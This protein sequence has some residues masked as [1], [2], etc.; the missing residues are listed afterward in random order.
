MEKYIV[1]L[2]INKVNNFIYVGV[3]KTEDPNKFDTYLGCG[4]YSN[5]PKSYNCRETA[6]QCAVAKYGPKNFR[7]KTLRIF[8]SLKPALQL[9]EKIVTQQFIER[10]D[11]YN[12]TVGGG[13]PPSSNKEIYQYDLEG[14]FIKEWKSI[15]SITD[16][17]KVNKDRVRMVINDKRSFEASYWSE[18]CFNH[19]DVTE[20]R[21]S[22]RGSIRQYTTDG[23]FL[24]SFRNTTEAAKQ[25]DIE[26]NQITNAICDKYATNGYW[27]LKEGETIES[28]LDGSIKNEPKVYLYSTS[29][30]FIK[31]FDNISAV[32]KEYKYN[33]NDLKRAIK[34]NA[35]FNDYYW[36]YNKYI[37][38]LLENP[39]LEQRSPRKVYQYTME[40]EFVR[41]W[42]SITSCKKHF[43]SVLQ[44]CLGK[45]N[46]C[47]KFKF[48]FD[49]LKI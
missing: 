29:G 25:L 2:T 10:P 47:K 22:S 30:E 26:R 35:L 17:Y 4:V 33:K 39:E 3:H 24:K 40:D 28:Y 42:D 37:N 19:L 15:K 6:F 12:Q 9:E 13:Y 20:Y 36:S 32:K 38:I 45:R 44:V 5:S 11:V 43:P 1:Y 41:E 31:E 27:F 48:S 23:V 21:P 16:Y 18:E 8:D 14:N 46:H 49:K 34:N 7:R